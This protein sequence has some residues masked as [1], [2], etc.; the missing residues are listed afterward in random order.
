M[1][2]NCDVTEC[3][4]ISNHTYKVMLK[5]DKEISFKAGQIQCYC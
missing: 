2:L 4:Q 5:A 1:Q 3:V